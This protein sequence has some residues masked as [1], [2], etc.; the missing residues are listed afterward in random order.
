[1]RTP[2]AQRFFTSLGMEPMTGTPAEAH[3][4]IVKEAAKW[5]Q[6]IKGMGIS[7]D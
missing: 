7:I 4:H 5:S 1:M 6:V 2:E 3:Q